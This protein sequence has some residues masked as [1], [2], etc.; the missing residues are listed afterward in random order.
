MGHQM[1]W[2]GSIPVGTAL[3]AVERDGDGAV[4]RG[5]GGDDALFDVAL[6]TDGERSAWKNSASHVGT[7]GRFRVYASDAD[8]PIGNFP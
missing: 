6:G 2:I 1:L 4:R 3:R 5:F 8:T 7:P